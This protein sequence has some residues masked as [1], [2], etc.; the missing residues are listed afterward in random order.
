MISL[1][2]GGLINGAMLAA[3]LISELSLV[4]YPGIDGHASD[5]SIFE[6][7]GNADERH[8][9]GQSLELLSSETA[10]NGIVW[11]RYRFHRKNS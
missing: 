8:A 1:Q 3:G 6:Y 7:L 2:G 5:P 11:L 9:A 4:I 10:G